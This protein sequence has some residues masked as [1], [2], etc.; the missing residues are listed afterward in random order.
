MGGV[1]S[2][3]L[4]VSGTTVTSANLLTTLDSAIQTL[5]SKRAGFGAAV[6]RLQDAGNQ[7]ESMQTNLSSALSSIQDVD[8]ASETANLAQQQVLAQAG[9]SVLSQANQAPQLALKLLGD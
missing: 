3:G 2:T 1:S 6:D 4:G 9:A 8:V 5:S 7:I